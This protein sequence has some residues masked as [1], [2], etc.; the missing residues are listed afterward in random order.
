M[1][2]EKLIMTN[3]G[4]IN[5]IEEPYRK[6]LLGQE[7][8]YEEKSLLLSTAII[9]FREYE[10]NKSIKMLFELAY[11]IIA[12]Y[13]V[14]CNDYTP[15]YDF[16]LNYGFFPIVDYIVEKV[17]EFTQQVTDIINKAIMDKYRM[18]EFMP[19]LQQYKA[20]ENVL[21]D[22]SG[23]D[24]S[25]IAPT[26]FGKSGLIISHIKKVKCTSLKAAIIVPSKSLLMQTYKYV[27]E[28]FTDIKIIL[29][30]QM[31]SGESSYI[32]VLTQERALR[33]LERHNTKFDYLY[34]DEAHN[35]FD[36]DVRNRLLARLI[37][38]SRKK[39]PACE[40]LYFSP[41]VQNSNN[42]KV[43]D[44]SAI[45]EYRID[46]NIKMPSYLLYDSGNCYIYNR[47]FN[48]KYDLNDKIDTAYEYIRSRATDKNLLYINSPK[49]MEKVTI[50]FANELED[51]DS[52]AISEIIES[53]KKHVHSEFQM[54]PLIKKGIVYLHG[55]LPD[56]VKDYIEYK[57][58]IT[59]EIKYISA[60]SVLLEGIN[61]PIS[62]LF[63]LSARGL[64][65]NKLINLSGRV[66]RLNSIFGNDANIEKLFPPIHFVSNE[67]SKDKMANYL[68][69]IRT[70]DIID[71]EEDACV[72]CYWYDPLEFKRHLKQK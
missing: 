27:K 33:L 55:K 3:I 44:A 31:F 14:A 8:T 28:A 29:H 66:N 16:S 17:P 19:T 40:I 12:R 51:I 1:A 32:A 70:N 56:Y 72:G 13:S 71:M 21:C 41:L 15:L 39:N 67:D 54:I 23:N 2:N 45:S 52:P 10:K 20:Y 63:I 68:V 58:A 22:E 43:L 9:L 48:K 5:S 47:F 35:L 7:L 69:R 46:N 59:P 37:R 49:R 62:S 64:D 53:V 4:K 24:I 26:S 34:I 18:P 6:L 50:K 42:L 60:N 25:F 36:T 65:T 30:D 61:L 11:E 38:L 57:A